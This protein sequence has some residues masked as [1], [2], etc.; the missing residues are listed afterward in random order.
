MKFHRLL[1]VSTALIISACTNVA[2]IKEHPSLTC[3]VEFIILG[4]G[5]DGGAPQIGK[6]DDPAWANSSLKLWA[7]SGA[8]V[9][10]RHASRYLFEATPDLREQMNLL[11]SMSDGGN[12]PLGLSGVFLTHAQIG[13][14]AGLIFVGHESIGTKGLNVFTLPRMQDYL[15]NNGPWEQLVNYKNINLIS[16]TSKKSVAFHG[17]LSVTAH[18][19]PHRDEYSETAGYVVKGPSKSV[20]FLPD[21]DDWGRWETQFNTRIEDMIAQVDV[22]YLDATFFDNNEL[23]GRDMSK[24]PHPRVVDSMHRFEKLPLVEKNKVRFFHINHSNKT[25]YASSKQYKLVQQKGFKI[26]KRGERVCLD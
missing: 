5:Q 23:P 24:I 18:L 3:E 15:E 8:L 12:A 2:V 10:H 21:I 13:H 16:I 14:Y 19:V 7:A 9:D 17:D 4:I 1:F 20:L 26:A 11:D 6:P 22:A 25:R